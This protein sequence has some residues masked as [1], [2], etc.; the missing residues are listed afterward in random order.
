VS[1]GC[2]LQDNA[3]R[4]RYLKENRAALHDAECVVIDHEEFA[5]KYLLAL[6]KKR[7]IIP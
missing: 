2:C 7:Y 6:L 5:D 3:G 1:Q 4:I